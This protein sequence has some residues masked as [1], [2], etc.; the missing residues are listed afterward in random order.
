MKEDIVPTLQNR[1]AAEGGTFRRHASLS[2]TSFRCVTPVVNPPRRPA[3]GE[4]STGSWQTGNAGAFMRA[5]ERPVSRANRM[6][7]VR[8]EIRHCLNLSAA[9]VAVAIA[10]AE[11]R[12]RNEWL[13]LRDRGAALSSFWPGN[14]ERPL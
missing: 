8:L 14:G 5:E 6:S 10:A 2:A 9:G 3:M 11:E 1:G 13:V 7:L 12:S 4:D